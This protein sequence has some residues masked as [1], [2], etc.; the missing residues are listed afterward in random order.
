MRKLLAFF[1]FVPALLAQTSTFPTS[2]DTDTF[3]KVAKN[4]V[5]TT[6]LASA[7]LGDTTLIVV[8]STG[9]VSNM[10]LTIDS[11][12]VSVCSV[13]GNVVNVGVSSCPNVDGRGFDGTTAIGHVATAK[14]SAFVDAWHHNAVTSALENIES[15]IGTGYPT[16]TELQAAINALPAGG[17]EIFMAAGT[18]TL[19]ARIL[20]PSNVKIRGRGTGTVLKI[21]VNGWPSLASGPFYCP[22][23]ANSQPCAIM[24]VDGASNVQLQDFTLDM[25][26]S[27]QG[28]SLG[29]AG[30]LFPNCAY[31][32]T[33]GLTVKAM[34]AGGAA[35]G[36][37]GS[38]TSHSLDDHDTIIGY[39]IAPCAGGILTQDGVIQN[40]FA[41]ATCDS[42]FTLNGDGGPT[43][44]FGVMA[45]N[46]AINTGSGAGIASITVESLPNAVVFGNSHSGPATS[47]FSVNTNLTGT[48]P[49]MIGFKVEGNTCTANASGGPTFCLT[50]SGLPTH[51]VQHGSITD[52]VFSGSTAQCVTLSGPSNAV[53]VTNVSLKGNH[54]TSCGNDG[55]WIVQG[56]TNI[57]ETNDHIVNAGNNGIHVFPTGTANI[58][59]AL[60]TITGSGSGRSIFDESTAAGIVLNVTDDIFNGIVSISSYAQQ[61]MTLANGANQDISTVIG[62]SNPAQ[63]DFWV[64]GPTGAFST[65][66]FANVF[67]GKTFT[68]WNPTGFAW[69]ITNGAVGSLIT[70]RVSTLT[71]ADLTNVL[72]ATFRYEPFLN[73]WV[74]ISHNP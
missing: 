23:S 10:L 28:G 37:L 43:A 33:S 22:N 19:N 40:N 26:G 59:L 32:G 9:M 39:G 51:V 46:I 65:G 45:H 48:T 55:I 52:N 21:A 34:K 36:H 20:V 24:S 54:F 44:G 67:N 14:V 6:L 71:G 30:A 18:T 41:T 66:G 38:T 29:G 16:S 69:T 57:T 7:A 63:A 4:Q 60:N 2:L 35:I 1:A 50:V 73:N 61:A 17:G 58:Q 13:S 64:S 47:A 3:F 5:Q 49:T 42:N 70:Q 62:A 74:V 72:T 25:N 31:C 12:I 53:A 56:S 68:L 8:N 27:N 15:A 11:E